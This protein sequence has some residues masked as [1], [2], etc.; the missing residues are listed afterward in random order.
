[1]TDQDQSQT[2]GKLVLATIDEELIALYKSRF[3]AMFP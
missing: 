3:A 2:T 1:M